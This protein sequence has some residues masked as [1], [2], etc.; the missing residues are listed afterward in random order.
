MSMSFLQS[1]GLSTT[2]HHNSRRSQVPNLWL[3]WKSSITPPNLLHC[4]Q[5]Q[6]TMEVEGAIITIIHAHCIY[7]QRRQLWTELQHIS[8]ANFP[9]LL[10]G[11]FNAY[12]SYSEKQGGN[13]PSAAAMNDFQECVSIAHLM[14]V[15]CNGFHHTWWNKQKG[16]TIELGSSYTRTLD[17]YSDPKVE[18]AKRGYEEMEQRSLWKHQS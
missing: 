3:F 12:L 6:L 11:D 13:I 4:S 2:F 10:M 16:G 8:N 7:I 9:W 14:E 5:Q 1:Q 17:F 15:P 18:E